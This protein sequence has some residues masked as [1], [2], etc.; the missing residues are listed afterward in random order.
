MQPHLEHRDLTTLAASRIKD[1]LVR[2]EAWIQERFGISSRPFFRPPFGAHNP[3][4]DNVAG[5]LGW[6]KVI[7]WNATFGDSIVHPPEFIIQQLRSSLRSGTI[8]LSHANHP[9]TAS[10]MDQII[11]IVEQSRLRPVTILEH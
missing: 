5:E 3:W 7:L 10:V 6:T 9:A 2:N 4:V 8:M 1:E 11:D